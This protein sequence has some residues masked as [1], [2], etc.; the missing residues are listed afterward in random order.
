MRSLHPERR[1]FYY[2]A[3]PGDRIHLS[4]GRDLRL[5]DGH[6][7]KPLNYFVYPHVEVAGQPW[8]GP[9]E[10]SFSYSTP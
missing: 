5:G 7:S 8:K 2:G 1:E 9:I 6:Q 3:H 10:K 4:T